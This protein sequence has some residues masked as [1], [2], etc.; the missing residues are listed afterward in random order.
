MFSGSNSQVCENGAIV[1]DGDVV[2]PFRKLVGRDPVHTG[3][4]DLV[5]VRALLKH[6]GRNVTILLPRLN[7]LA[8]NQLR[9]IDSSA[10][11]V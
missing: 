5:I 1:A 7:C 2:I 10:C 3:E 9:R 11:D 8:F 6:I 4:R